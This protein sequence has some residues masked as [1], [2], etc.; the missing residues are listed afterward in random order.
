V[1]G[2][3]RKASRPARGKG[4]KRIKAKPAAKKRVATPKHKKARKIARKSV[5]PQ[6]APVLET[7]IVDIVEEPVPGVVTVTEFEETR[8]VR[9]P[10]MGRAQPEEGPPEED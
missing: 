9:R 10:G 6:G 4:A 5:R 2:K 7:T 1:R 3:S 8:V